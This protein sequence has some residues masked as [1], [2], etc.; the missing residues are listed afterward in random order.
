MRGHLGIALT[1]LAVGADGAAALEPTR[2]YRS[3]CPGA[4]M[5]I[6]LV[7]TPRGPRVTLERPGEPGIE[8]PDANLAHV[9]RRLFFTMRTAAGRL[10]EFQGHARTDA[11]TGLLS[12]DR[13][14]TRVI[15]L[16]LADGGAPCEDGRPPTA[17]SKGISSR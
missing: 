6:T 4:T 14:G 1:L 12:D 7:D 5:T 15:A 13:G 17:R 9:S 8:T 2:V 11:L 10:I 16:P 3:A